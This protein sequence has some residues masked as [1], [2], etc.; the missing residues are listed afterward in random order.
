MAAAG[1]GCGDEDGGAVRAPLLAAAAAV[2][3]LPEEAAAALEEVEGAAA[4][5]LGGRTGGDTTTTTPEAAAA[6]AAEELT[7][8]LRLFLDHVATWTALGAAA[9][10]WD[11]LCA[12]ATASSHG[13]HGDMCRPVLVERKH[14]HVSCVIR[15]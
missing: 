10:Q 1:A 2:G 11:V 12:L 4:A 13:R 7:A 9:A 15:D 6:A 5:A 8:L 14:M 3:S